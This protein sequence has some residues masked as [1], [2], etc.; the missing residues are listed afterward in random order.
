MT[1]K[2]GMRMIALVVIRVMTMMR[3]SKRSMPMMIIMTM[4][5]VMTRIRMMGMINGE[6]DGNN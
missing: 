3:R 1:R 2:R 4:A 6:V 5:L